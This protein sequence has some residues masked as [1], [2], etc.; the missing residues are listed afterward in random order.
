MSETSADEN[1]VRW[2][3]GRIIATVV[4]VAI[5]ATL[6]Y[7]FFAGHSELKTNSNVVLPGAA[8][9]PTGKSVPPDFQVATLDGRSF[10]LSEY[11]GKVL[12]VDFWAT[13]CGPCRQEIPQLVRIAHQNRDRGVEVVGL[14]IDD[15]GRSTP[16][17]IRSFIAQYD[18]PYTVGLA[19][20]EM[21]IAY[22][23]DEEDA[24][25]QTLIFDRKGQVI[26]HF[27]GYS[28]GDARRLDEIVNR[29]IA[30]S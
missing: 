4:V 18:I 28:E 15:N 23:G 22:L 5:V 12:V 24:I 25:P 30:A 21:F 17:A 6:G 20:N 27:I 1:E 10:K 2:S 29:A 11:R 16:E 3:P 9:D 14:H 7:T 13:W 8:V 19:T 26:G